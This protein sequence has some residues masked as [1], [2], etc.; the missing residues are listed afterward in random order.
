MRP[1]PTLPFD[2]D[3]RGSL[4]FG[5]VCCTNPL[6]ALS[7]WG[8]SHPGCSWKSHCLKA[9]RGSAV[10]TSTAFAFSCHSWLYVPHVDA[11]PEVILRKLAETR[12]CLEQ[13]HGSVPTVSSSSLSAPLDFALSFLLGLSVSDGAAVRESGCMTSASRQLTEH[14]N[15]VRTNRINSSSVPQSCQDCFP[16]FRRLSA[17]Q[18]ISLHGKG[19][20][21]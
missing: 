17:V 16:R 8:R 11:I 5:W 15:Y 12:A 13:G 7:L 14:S 3:K 20:V 9:G 4:G 6:Q 21:T 1:P 18:T 2:S 19:T 10:S